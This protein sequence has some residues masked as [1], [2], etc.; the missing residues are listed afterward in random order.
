M[1]DGKNLVAV[2]LHHNLGLIVGAQIDFV[3]TVEGEG[4]VVG[5]KLPAINKSQAFSLVGLRAAGLVF[6]FLD[7]G[8]VELDAACKLFHF[9]S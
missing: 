1:T 9:F 7:V 2:A 5:W 3:A 6:F 4:L 8:E